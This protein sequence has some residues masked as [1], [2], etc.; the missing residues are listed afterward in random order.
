MEQAYIDTPIQV[1][2]LVAL[3][4]KQFLP[5]AEIKV[6]KA[7]VFGSIQKLDDVNKKAK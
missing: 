3:R 1:N 7:K 4:A 6:L 2:D 5:K